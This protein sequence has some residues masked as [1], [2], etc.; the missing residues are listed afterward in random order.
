MKTGQ[1]R[2][3]IGEYRSMITVYETRRI[4]LRQKYTVGTDEYR[5]RIKLIN[6]RLGTFKKGVRRLTVI[7]EKLHTIRKAIQEFIDIDV[8][9]TKFA[10]KKEGIQA[11][12]I[13]FK[14]CMENGIPGNYPNDYVGNKSPHTA[15]KIRTRFSLSFKVKPDNKE[16]YHRFLTFMKDK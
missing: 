10:Q 3:T 8:R 2:K 9:T 13:F 6:Q 14:F 15:S 11:K 1:R 16:L 12:G 7:K 5:K 4:I